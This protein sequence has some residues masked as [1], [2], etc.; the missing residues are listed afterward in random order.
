MLILLSKSKRIISFIFEAENEVEE[1]GLASKMLTLSKPYHSGTIFR[2]RPRL[3]THR[4]ITFDLLIIDPKVDI[5]SILGAILEP[6][7]MKTNLLMDESWAQA[8]SFKFDFN[9]D[10]FSTFMKKLI[11]EIETVSKFHSS[12]EAELKRV[13]AEASAKK[14][15]KQ[16]ESKSTIEAMLK[17]FSLTVATS[18]KEVDHTQKI[19][20]YLTQ[21]LKPEFMEKYGSC[22]AIL[23]DSNYEPIAAEFTIPL[24]KNTE[25]WFKSFKERCPEATLEV[26]LEDTKNYSAILT[27]PVPE[28]LLKP[29]DIEPLDFRLLQMGTKAKFTSKA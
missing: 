11:N 6:S 13:L 23:S 4:T 8:K 5:K 28:D 14:Q 19:G 15:D 9:D 12:K 2:L 17:A 26:S 1:N 25:A 3:E 27:I 10:T 16:Q 20:D 18:K 21:L 22:W 24:T 29:K 7:T